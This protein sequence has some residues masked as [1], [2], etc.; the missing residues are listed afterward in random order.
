MIC[1]QIFLDI[2]MSKASGLNASFLYFCGIVLEH[3][4]WIGPKYKINSYSISLLLLVISDIK[5]SAQL[6]LEIR[7]HL[8]QQF[9]WFVNQSFLFVS[10]NLC[11]LIT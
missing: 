5:L 1:I 7:H 2:I 3:S 10:I 4:L 11:T 9:S 6:S 8:S